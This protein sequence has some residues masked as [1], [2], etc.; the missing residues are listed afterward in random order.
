[1]PDDG[2]WGADGERLQMHLQR[3][4]ELR[5][6]TASGGFPG[7]ELGLVVK[8]YYKDDSDNKDQVYNE[9][10]V[11]IIRHLI[12]LKNVPV[13]SLYQGESGG[14]QITLKPATTIPEV[15]QPESIWKNF[16]DSDGDLV[17]VSYIGEK[18]PVIDGCMNHI[19]TNGAADWY[20]D[21]SGGEIASFYYNTTRQHIDDDGNIQIDMVGTSKDRSILINVDG[22]QFMRIFQDGG[23][24]DV[25]IELGNNSGEQ[26]I[27][28]ETHRSWFNSNVDHHVH[29]TGT[30]VTDIG[31]LSGMPHT[32]IISGATAQLS[33]HMPLSHLTNK[34]TA[35]G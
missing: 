28:G 22:V 9:Y 17:S 7:S 6:R 35:E 34:V 30:L 10:D 16:M 11:F 27:L 1:M 33:A 21:S 18:W 19:R 2:L 20:A 8:R 31:T 25:R 23:S 24:G 26:V 3:S 14:Y 29:G 15:T 13:K 32:H 5:G 12:Y 4:V